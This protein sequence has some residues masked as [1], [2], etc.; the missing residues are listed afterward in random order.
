M[1]DSQEYWIKRM[2]EIMAHVDRT[3]L[4]FFDELQSVYTEARQNAL[5]EIYGF[6]TQYAKDNA[7]TVQEAKKRLMR[8]DLSDYRANAEKYL[9]QAEKDPELLKRL[10]EQYKAGKVTR[11][12][13]LQL[14][15][16]YQLGKL[17]G[18]LH[19]SFE[20]YLKEVA[21]YTYR[22]VAFGNS[23]STLNLPALKQLIETPF[24]GKNY[25]QSIWGNVDDLAEDLKKL[26]SQAFI[27]G[28]NPSDLARELRKKY[29]VA[30]ARAEAIVRTDGTNII[31]N[32][33][34]KR[35]LEAGLTK[36]DFLAHI[37]SRTTQTCKSLNG[38]TFDLKDYQPGTN[39]PPMH[40]NCRSTIVPN[41]EELSAGKGS[42]EQ[43]AL[44]QTNMR[45]KVGDENY[46]AFIESLESI[47]NPKI[48]ALL[49]KFG[50]QLDF[51][52][53]SDGK[54]FVRGNMVQLSQEAFEGAAY[55]NPLQVVFHE[56]G[57]AID[58]LGI[59]AFGSE[60]DRV[61]E[62]PKYKLK[63]DINN[64][65]L[66]LFNGDLSAIKGADYQK[67][68]NL[69]KMDIFD[70]GAIIR[71]YKKLAEENPKMYSSLSDM[72]ESTGAFI[73]HPLDFGHGLKYWKT[74]GMQEA[75]FFAHMAETVVNEDSR[76]MMY[77]LFPSASKKWDK[78]LEDILGAVD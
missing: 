60:Y 15:L 28:M 16:T 57:H 53:L 4:D 1:A 47:E 71:K 27:K 5:K 14:D 63:N 75:E 3:D 78:M 69:K 66:N 32:A 29:N 36:Y 38:K 62:M 33:T 21:Q 77:E 13:A 58:N 76:K 37:D 35:Y 20:S 61:S 64:D 41:D 12:E 56:L 18:E 10:N 52:D 43:H 24:N 25:S 40:V 6:Y 2:D 72:M 48:K 46:E 22:K 51:N 23:A 26:L 31:N 45:E 54:D 7:I 42:T 50:N 65:L 39:A 19:K 9:K 67:L 49:E 8:E 34:V 44:D 11:L 55:K 74:Y 30:K 59:E 73:D 68:K 70:Q 17:A